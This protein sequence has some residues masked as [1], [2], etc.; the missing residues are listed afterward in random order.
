MKIGFDA[1]RAFNNFTGLGNYSRFV[2][3]ALAQSYPQHQYFLF[4]PEVKNNIDTSFLINNPVFEIIEPQG[5]YQWLPKS[6]WRTYAQATDAKKH[7]IELY[8]G[9]S[10]E[11]PRNLS[12]SIKKV[13]TIHDLIFLRYPDYYK[14]ID[15]KIYKQKTLHACKEANAIVAISQ[16]TAD[17]LVNL[18]GIAREKIKV[19]YQGM[20]PLF[21]IK[22]DA[23][24]IEEVKTKYHLP[25]NYL[26]NVGTIETRKNA[27]LIVHAMQELKKD[28][29]LVLIGRRTAY[30]SELE[31]L[32]A[33]LNLTER[34]H[35]RDNINFTD[36]PL[37]YQG[38]QIFIYPSRFEGF[39]IPIIEAM[40]SGIPVVA[41]SGSCLAEAGG[42]ACS[43]IAPDDAVALA[44][45]VD[46]I[47]SDQSKTNAM[48]IAGRE[49]IKK[50]TP[51]KIAAELMQL[52]A[53]LLA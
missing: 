49:Q 44:A 21:H 30:A 40:A 2:L 25:S 42:E 50:F 51:E 6:V 28:V 26:L 29:H 33:K 43:Y 46:A 52:Y 14:H 3:N 36:L 31:V 12:A 27:A 45:A 1:K 9:L 37:L 5:L 7:R 4:T 18:L 35:I 24:K 48:V 16:Q 53:S 47:I 23:A 13:V 10:N 39:G 11:L 32:A 15:R 41:A 17:D 22:Y 38:A 34:L 19:I 20:H 8:H